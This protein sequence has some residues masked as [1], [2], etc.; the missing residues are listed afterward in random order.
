MRRNITL[1]GEFFLADAINI[2][3]ENHLKMRV[4][5]VET[6]LDAGTT[7]DVLST[8][9]YLLDHGHDNT[10]ETMLNKKSVVLPP[11]FIHPQAVVEN[12]VV[13]P[14]TSIGAN[15]TV[16]S[17]II[18]DSIIEEGS[19]LEDVIL[20]HSLVGRDTR[21]HSQ[22]GVLSVGDQTVLTV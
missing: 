5:Q 11:V 9:R 12:S 13:G 15:C 14:Y 19:I 1:K 3:L 17:C 10:Q 22:A 4:E 8:N 7:E 6:W 18:R 2:L 20:E 16:Q 21:I